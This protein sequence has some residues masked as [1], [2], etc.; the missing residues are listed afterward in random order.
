MKDIL[1]LA[2]TAFGGPQAHI[3]M[4]LD[5]LVV[6]RKYLTEAELIELNALC[7]ILP[8]PTSTQTLMAVGYKRGGT[9]LAFWTLC[10]WILPATILMSAAAIGLAYIQKQEIS[11]D[12]TRFIQPM[13]IGFVSFA[14]LRISRKVVKTKTAFVLMILAG[15]ASYFY[16]TPWVFPIILIAGGLVTAVKF[17]KEEKEEKQKFDIR[18]RFLILYGAVFIGVAILGNATKGVLLLIFENFYRNGSLIFG[19]GQV[20]IPILYTEFVTFKQFLT[21]DEF[22]S[23][24][25][26]VQAVPG[27]VFSF[28]AFVGALTMYKRLSWLQTS[29]LAGSGYFGTFFSNAFGGAVGGILGGLLGGLTASIAVF[30][31]GMFLIFFVIRFW[32]QLKKFRPVKA[33]LEGINGASAGLVIAGA[34]LLLEPIEKSPV[35]VGIM[36]STF[37]ILQFT[38][39]PAPFLI[40]IGLLIGF[41]F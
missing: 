13:A 30:L 23:G 10:V 14:A 37:L 22:L 31:P 9:Y 34:F 24:Y 32:E 25:A 41:I 21:A 20:L 5:I 26:L 19:G 8:G 40:L 12:F 4:F 28:A 39:I 17:K 16:R 38:K 3:A 6:K 15:I 7:Q 29:F 36:L 11:L 18:W 27:P 33:S 2:L 1:L 35:N